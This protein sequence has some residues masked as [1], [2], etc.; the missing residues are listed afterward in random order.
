MAVPSCDK[1]RFVRAKQNKFGTRAY[2]Y[3][4]YVIKT[5]I[6]CEIVI[7]AVV[8]I[9][10]IS[11]VDYPTILYPNEFC[12]VAVASNSTEVIIL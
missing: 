7:S 8:S 1:K 11:T 4:N 9:V 6:A 3:L 2:K 10:I 5:S 12:D